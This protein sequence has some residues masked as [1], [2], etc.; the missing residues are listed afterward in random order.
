MQKDGL[1]RI[2]QILIPDLGFL[3]LQIEAHQ[4]VVE[5]GGWLSGD[6]QAI[7]DVM[8]PAVQTAIVD[9]GQ[10]DRGFQMFRDAPRLPISSTGDE[11]WPSTGI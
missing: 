8:A 2:V 4:L 11:G 3:S 9:G 6:T 10:L 7:G 1:A 5:R